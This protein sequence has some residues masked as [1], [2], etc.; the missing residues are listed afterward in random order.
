MKQSREAKYTLAGT[1][2]MDKLSYESDSE[3]GDENKERGNWSGKLDFI[4]SLI[5]YCIGMSNVWRFPYLCYR[6]GG[7]A[8]LIPYLLFMA[9]CGMPL[10]FLEVAFGQFCSEGPIT[11]WKVCRLFKGAG[12]GMVIITGLTTIYYNAIIMYIL[13]F[14]ISSFTAI[15]NLPWSTCDNWWNTEACSTRSKMAMLNATNVTET[16]FAYSNAN[17]TNNLNMT[18]NW[19]N[20]TSLKPVTASQEFWTNRVL[21]LSDGIDSFG[22]IQWDLALLLLLA[23]F[24]IFLCLI[25]GIKTTGKVV[26]VTATFPY[27]VI[28]ILIIRG[29]TLP[30]AADGLK[31]FF[32][33]RWEQLANFKVWSDAAVQ[34]FF[35]LGPSWGGLLTMASY[36]KF[37]HNCLRDSIFVPIVNSATSIYIGIAVF[38]VLGF[39]SHDTGVP[40]KDVVDAG[41]GLV[42]VVYPEALSRIPLAPLW[43]ALFF[44]MLFTVGLDSQFVMLEGVCSAIIDSWP[45]VLRPK[46]TLF[47][48]VICICFYLLGLP[49]TTKGGNYLLVL[50]DWYISYFGLMVIALVECLVFAAVY[51]INNFYDDISMM[52]RQRLSIW[53]KICWMCITPLIVLVI[54]FMMFATYVPIYIGDYVYPKW[55]EGL[56]LIVASSSVIIIPVWMFVEYFTTSKGDTVVQRLKSLTIPTEDWGPAVEKFRTGRYKRNETPITVMEMKPPSYQPHY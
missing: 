2:H 32:V 54:L 29:V 34:I 46:K 6:N 31:F 27:L 20:D 55:A 13:Y 36:N 56:G 25:K 12:I 51:G 33:P 23:W 43:S 38:S 52:I 26:Y 10:F 37:R 49:M 1:D 50:L 42:F 24:I 17:S 5:G 3:D 19:T 28:T 16:A 48:L 41:P 35:S 44:L 9:L 7:G 53:W 15:P 47:V 39:L 30:G 21:R 22:G 8:F 4:L 11:A 40:I 18:M 14:F 45:K